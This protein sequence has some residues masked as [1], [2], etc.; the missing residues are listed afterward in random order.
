MNKRNVIAIDLA[1]QVFQVVLLNRQDKAVSNK[2]MRPKRF[3]EYLAKQSRSLVAFEACGRAHH[4]ARVANELGHEVVILPA[5]LVAGFRQGHKTDGKDALAIGMAARQP[6]IRAV[7]PMSLAQQALQS[8]QRVAQHVSDEKTAT[9]NMLR[10]LLAE[11]GLE[12]P[13]GDKALRESMPLILE[14]ADNGLPLSVRE[15]LFMA[16]QLWGTLN[17]Q[18]KRLDRL[19]GQR[20]K[21]EEVCRWLMELEGVGAKNAVGL[22][23]A[24]GDGRHFK[25][26]RNASACIGATPKQHSTGGRERIGHIGRYCGNTRLRASLIMGAHAV[27]QV[28]E[29]RPP[30]S[31]KERWLKTLIERRGKGRAAVALVNKTIRTAWAML[32]YCE[33]YR[34]PQNLAS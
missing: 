22:Y 6:E 21:D 19:L 1:K 2:S 28:L 11:F 5:K 27:I 10:G 12:I 34:G 15:S 17:D 30:R 32:Y 3:R 8:D 23:V 20:A 4:W 9:G 13:R 16:W 18:V 25:N 29:K 33:P 31:D 7:A 24:L 14:D 26:G